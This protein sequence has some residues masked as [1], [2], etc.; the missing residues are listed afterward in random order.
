MLTR[1]K[2]GLYMIKLPMPFR[3]GYVNVFVYQHKHGIVLFDSGV[4]SDECFAELEDGLGEIGASI[5]DVREIYLSHFHVDHSGLAGRIK[6]LSGAKVFISQ[7]DALRLKRFYF[8]SDG[9]RLIDR[10][11]M[12]HG[13]S[14]GLVESIKRMLNFL[15]KKICVFEVDVYL[16]P[17]NIHVIGEEELEILPAPGHTRGQVCFFFKRLGILLSCDHILPDIT[18]NLSP[19]IAH[20]EFRPLHSFVNSL[21]AMRDLPVSM[22]YPSH[23]EPFSSLNRRIDEIIVHHRERREII[24]NTLNSGPK[25]AYQISLDVFGEDLSEFDRFLAVNEIITHVMELEFEGKILKESRNGVYFFVKEG[26]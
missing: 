18:P 14:G 2:D 21:T 17:N 26:K 6:A 5:E 4:D 24:L 7:E 12:Q 19:D 11:Y 15:R 3:E 16:L 1:I 9:E 25:T 22:I 10:F 13:V 20:P 8:T 23:G